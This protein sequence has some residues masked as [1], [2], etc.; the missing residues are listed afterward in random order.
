MESRASGSSSSEY[1]R[2]CPFFFSFSF[3]EYIFEKKKKVIVNGTTSNSMGQ[4]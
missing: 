3:C 2:V 4:Q 1:V